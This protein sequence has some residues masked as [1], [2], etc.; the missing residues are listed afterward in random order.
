MIWLWNLCL[1][2]FGDLPIKTK[3]YISFGWLCFFATLLAAV[4]LFGLSQMRAG[5]PECQAS[6]SI[7]ANCNTQAAGEASTQTAATDRIFYRVGCAVL[8]LLGLMFLLSLVMAWRLSAIISVPIQRAC[9][10]LER[11]ASR[12]LTAEAAV[13]ST[14]EVGRMGTAFNT[15][16]RHLQQIIGELSGFVG[17][18]T[19]TVEGLFRETQTTTTNCDRQSVL[20]GQMLDAIHQ[21]TATSARIASNS[22]EAAGAS[23]ESARAAGDGGEI[24]MQAAATMAHIE[25][26]SAAISGHMALLDERAREIGKAVNEIRDISE[27]TNLLALNAAIEA[28]RAGEEGRGFAVVAGEV[29]R[30]AER[31]RLATEEISGMVLSIKQEAS[32]TTEA[33]A[34]S[35]TSVELGK[36]RTQ[37]A[38]RML[39]DILNRASRANGIVANTAQEARQ[40]SSVSEQISDCAENVARLA[41]ASHEASEQTNRS[42]KR[43]GEL[44][45]QL[46]RIVHQFR[47]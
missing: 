27:N 31:T 38:Q 33:V 3:L 4:S 47:M 17:T 43:I 35:R 32:N 21:L 10:L 34:G 13:V 41:A 44:S 22:D 25:Q 5:N 42:G 6:A 18:L 46:D 11:L 29:R 9:V 26:S 30:L 2:W 36:A 15:T 19:E 7:S 40:Q 39:G 24:M 23:Q 20:A 37:D 8:G 16:T 45:A 12:D 14:D 28:A 1:R